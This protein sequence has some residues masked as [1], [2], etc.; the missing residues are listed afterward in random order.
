[1]SISITQP[2]D[3]TLAE[4][5]KDGDREAFSELYGRYFPAV[6]DFLA[7]TL[8]DPDEAGDITQDA[9]LSAMNSIGGLKD[10]SKFKSWL[11]T[12]ARNSALRRIERS[13]RQRP[14]PTA[15]EGPDQVELD[16]VDADRLSDPA[17]AAE[18]NE[19]AA[20]VWEAADGLDRDAYSLLDLHVRQG[21]QAAEIAGV[22]NITRNNAN[23]RLSRLRR[24]MESA[25]AALFLLRARGKRCAVLDGEL[26]THDAERLSPALQQVI[27]G[28]A[29]GCAECSERRKRLVAPLAAFGALAPVTAPPGLQES[30][31]ER[32]LH[33]WPGGS[34]ASQAGSGTPWQQIMLVGGGATV[35]AGILGVSLLAWFGQTPPGDRNNEGAAPPESSVTSVAPSP[36]EATVA[37]SPTVEA[38]ASEEATLTIADAE[39]ETP[40]AAATAAP[41]T[42]AATSSADQNTTVPSS[43]TPSATNTVPVPRTALPTPEPSPSSTSSAAPSISPTATPS[44]PIATTPAASATPTATLSPTPTPTTP[45]PTPTPTPCTA[46]QGQDRDCDGVADS[47]EVDYGSDPDEGKST[48]EHADYDVKV[49]AITCTDGIDND[50]DKTIDGNDLGCK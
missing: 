35:A 12:I 26:S 39:T 4:R 6:Y 17:T 36:T 21:L 19:A 41:G 3:S 28:H 2:A 29:A 34:A 50:G 30:L 31:G 43:S 16:V 25:T 9:F 15:D 10:T 38:N 32:L 37:G 47:I 27:E 8:K 18:A 23:V 13:A 1:M 33:Q 20:V 42:V 48:P 22:L 49:G 7:R 11:F 44:L 14:W 45:P 46:P 40:I 5:A 24:A